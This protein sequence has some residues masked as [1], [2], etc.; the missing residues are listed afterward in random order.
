MQTVEGIVGKREMEEWRR[1]GE[2][3][4]TG[5]EHGRAAELGPLLTWL[6]WLLLPAD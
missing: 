6:I 4:Q 1:R 3:T 2:G 5:R